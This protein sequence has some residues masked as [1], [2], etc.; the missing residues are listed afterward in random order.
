[1]RSERRSFAADSE[2]FGRPL[3]LQW[4]FGELAVRLVDSLQ[5]HREMGVDSTS[6][7]WR[8]VQV[9]VEIV[10]P[11][12]LLGVLYPLV[13]NLANHTPGRLISM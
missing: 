1:M 11:Y 5:A 4:P 2:D 13:S 9:S 7:S 10:A 8:V 3:A 6:M 12:E